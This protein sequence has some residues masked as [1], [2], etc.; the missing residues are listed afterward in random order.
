VIAQEVHQVA[1]ELVSED[2]D[3]YLGVAYERAV[4]LLIEAIKEQQAMIEA[5]SDKIAAMPVA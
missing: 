5:L 1:P 3:G 2:E 4:A